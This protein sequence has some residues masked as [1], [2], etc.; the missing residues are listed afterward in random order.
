[1]SGA[2]SADSARARSGSTRAS[3]SSMAKAT[4]K[5]NATSAAMAAASWMAILMRQTPEPL[6]EQQHPDKPPG[7]ICAAGPPTVAVNGRQTRVRC[8]LNASA[9]SKRR[10]ERGSAAPGKQEGRRS[11]IAGPGIQLLYVS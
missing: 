6:G 8:G 2:D 7:G 5:P 4:Q 10:P 1:R 3:I 11:E 9:R